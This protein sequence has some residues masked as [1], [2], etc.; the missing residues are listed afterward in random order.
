[1]N[2]IDIARAAADSYAEYLD[3]K[4]KAVLPTGERAKVE[5]V[6]L[7]AL[8]QEAEECA[9]EAKDYGSCCIAAEISHGNSKATRH[10]VAASDA[11]AA[12]I[13]ARKDVI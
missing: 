1:M 10:G 6:I 8:Q 9:K 2:Q 12:Q 13:R 5:S 11:I 3:T 7:A 4:Y